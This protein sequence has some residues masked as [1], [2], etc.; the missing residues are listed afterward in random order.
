MTNAALQ[1]QL[2]DESIGLG[3]KKYRENLLER[4]EDNLPP[5]LKLM[6]QTIEPLAAA[7]DKKVEE[8]LSGTAFRSASVV[9]YLSQFDSDAV[10]FMTARTVIH[11]FSTTTTVTK[12]ALELAAR[13]E[14]LLNYDKL[15]KENPRAH[16]GLMRVLKNHPGMNL[17]YRYIV[18][19]KQQKWA[20]VSRI[21]WEN[22]ERLRLGTMLIHLFCEVTGLAQVDMQ[23]IGHNKTI[24]ILVASPAAT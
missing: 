18:I 10:A 11:F 13:L 4:G 22:G 19:R 17:G 7:I 12:V 20:N 24:N 16:K 8:G 5:G 14:A 6:K 2:E 1:Q 9:Q 3:I 23:V 21:K 15:K